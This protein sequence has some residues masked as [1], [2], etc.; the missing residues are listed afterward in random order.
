MTPAPQT[1]PAAEKHPA[2]EH[3][4]AAAAIGTFDGVHRGHEA[5]IAKLRDVSDERHLTPIAVTFDR[6]P[7]DLIA[8]ERAPKAITT[9]ERKARLLKD[10]GVTPV[11]LPFDETMRATTALDWMRRLKRDYNVAAIVVGYDNT[12]GSDGVNLSIADYRRLGQSLGIDIIEAP[13]VAAVSS[14]AIRKAVGEGDVKRAAEMLGRPY[15]LTG[16]VV[17]GNR[18]GRTI[19]FPTA[20]INPDPTLAIPADGVYAATAILSDGSKHPAMV[21]IGRR[22]T[23]RRGEQRT[24]E[25]HVINWKGDLYGSQIGLDFTSRLRDEVRFN[26]IEALRA[27]L[28]KDRLAALS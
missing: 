24:I 26:S 13:F 20:N 25:A 4:P 9:I 19:G 11:V 23:V 14:S 15:R 21:N 5:V 18:L 2:A 8:P 1:Q 22:P 10:A 12:F 6:H 28:E 27:Q 16:T 7:L 17:D 3:H